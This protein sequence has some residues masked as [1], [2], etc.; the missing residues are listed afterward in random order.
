MGAGVKHH[1]AL[2]FPIVEATGQESPRTAFT[3]SSMR[4]WGT[5][6]PPI[7]TGEA[8]GEAEEAVVVKGGPVA[9]KVTE[10]HLDRHAREGPSG[11]PAR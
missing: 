11:R 1:E 6:S 2:P 8:V 7:L 3:A 5:I 9:G 10:H 4:R